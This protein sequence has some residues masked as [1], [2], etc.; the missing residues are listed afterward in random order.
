MVNLV[1]NGIKY[2]DENGTVRLS[3]ASEAGRLRI[4]VW[5]S[6]PG[7]PASEQHRLF[8]PFSRLRSP[9]LSRKS[10]TGIGLYTC[11]RILEAHHGAIAAASQAGQW[12]EFGLSY[13]WRKKQRRF[14]RRTALDRMDPIPER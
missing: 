4:G 6:G 10:G 8:Q 13:P 14:R 7:F 2:G 5:N 1:A 11:W 12:A 9:A 3:V